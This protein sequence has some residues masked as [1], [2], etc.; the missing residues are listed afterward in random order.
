MSNPAP[1]PTP[2]VE[3]AVPDWRHDAVCVDLE[4]LFDAALEGDPVAVGAA[5]RVCSTCPV[6]RQCLTSGVRDPHGVRAGLDAPE[7]DPLAR[8]YAL[9]RQLVASASDALAQTAAGDPGLREALAAV[10][11]EADAIS[12]LALTVAAGGAGQTELHD[13]TALALDARHAT[14][15]ALGELYLRPMPGMD[16]AVTRLMAAAVQTAAVHA[17]PTSTVPSIAAV[18]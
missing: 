17:A 18:A 11:A 5:R 8:A 9:Y 4:D 16:R 3:H 1:T 7:R 14:A 12:S 13:L 6:R 2:T 15:Q 10:E